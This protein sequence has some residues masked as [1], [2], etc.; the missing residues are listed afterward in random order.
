MRYRLTD[1]ETVTEEG[2]WRFTVHS[3]SGEQEVIL[4]PCDGDRPVAAWVNRCT[5][6]DQ[7]LHREG[8]GAVV[9]EGGIVCPKHG[10]V[11]DSCSGECGNG[12][13]DGTTLLSVDIEIENGQVYLT[14]ENLRFLRHGPADDGDDDEMPGSTSHLRF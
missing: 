7:K 5:H 1:V 3:N 4:V 14:D 8:V 10:S 9:R 12:P 11:F 2:S 13:A 6:E